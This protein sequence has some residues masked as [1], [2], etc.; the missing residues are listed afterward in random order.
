MATAARNAEARAAFP[1]P[2]VMG[3]QH[4]KS[5]ECGGGDA[6]RGA[7]SASN[8]AHVYGPLNKVLRIPPG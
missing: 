1:D 3:A 4:P 8:G 5:A 2:A 6:V 7:L